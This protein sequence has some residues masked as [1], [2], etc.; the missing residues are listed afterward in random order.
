MEKMHMLKNTLEREI[1]KIAGKGNMNAGDLEMVSKL[2]WSLKNACKIEMYEDG[3]YSQDGGMWR[4]E[5][6]YS[7]RGGHRM[8]RADGMSYGESYN[9]GYSSR[10]RRDSRG[11]FT[12]YSMNDAKHEMI[13]DLR[14]MMDMEGLEPHDRDVLKKAMEQLSR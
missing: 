6:G 11:R 7:D 5:G 9:S 13:E 8:S 14:E 10:R 4:A 2:L 1:D 3:G 12:S